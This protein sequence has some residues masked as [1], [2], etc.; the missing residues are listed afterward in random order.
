MLTALIQGFILLNVNHAQR[1]RDRQQHSAIA[2]TSQVLDSS[3]NMSDPSVCLTNCLSLHN[4]A[5]TMGGRTV[6]GSAIA[7]APC[8]EVG[9]FPR[10]NVGRLAHLARS[11][12]RSTTTQKGRAVAERTVQ[13]APSVKQ[14]TRHQTHG[15]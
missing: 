9:V 15:I 2:R 10:T 13:L 11:G 4:R 3:L 8:V 6:T 5:H 1:K 12:L 14:S 7:S